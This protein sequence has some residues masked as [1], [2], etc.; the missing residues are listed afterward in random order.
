MYLFGF[1]SVPSCFGCWRPWLWAISQCSTVSVIWY[2]CLP[3]HAQHCVLLSWNLLL[4]CSSLN[5]LFVPSCSKRTVMSVSDLKEEV[6]SLYHAWRGCCG[7]LL[8]LYS[9][10]LTKVELANSTVECLILIVESLCHLCHGCL[11]LWCVNFD[12]DNLDPIFL[13]L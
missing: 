1:F 7:V 6:L 13:Q 4:R 11:I 10:I 8:F 9:V 2:Y 3:S 5:N 12:L